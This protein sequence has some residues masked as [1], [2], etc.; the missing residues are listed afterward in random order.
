MS[1]TLISTRVGISLSG[2][3]LEVLLGKRVNASQKYN[4]PENIN[5]YSGH[6]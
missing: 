3:A 4:D 5:F 2:R 6:Y 1:K